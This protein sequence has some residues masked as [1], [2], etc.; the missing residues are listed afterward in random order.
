MADSDGQDRLTV[1]GV[2]RPDD[3]EYSLGRIACTLPVSIA[4]T[5]LR[6][7]SSRARSG[8]RLQ[9]RAAR[10]PASPIA[11]ADGASRRR[12]AIDP[13]PR[14]PAHDRVRD[15]PQ[16]RRPFELG[17]QHPGRPAWSPQVSGVA[18]EEDHCDE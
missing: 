12:S 4:R 17:Y 10:R 1:F 11:A 13:A 18:P 8:V 2:D 7:A 16:P 6:S 9:S 15:I 5:E 14:S 3:E